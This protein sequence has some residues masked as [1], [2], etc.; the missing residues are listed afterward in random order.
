M[1]RE[2]RIGNFKGFAG[3]HSL[4][5]G[6]IN[7]F[8]GA[9]SAGK[10]ALLESLL[11]LRQSIRRSSIISD[12]GM[13]P[14]LFNG[15]LVD[16]GSFQATIN[17]HNIS[18][19]LL[20]GG[21]YEVTNHTP[22]DDKNPDVQHFDIEVAWDHETKSQVLESC[23]YRVD[24]A[25]ENTITFK[26][27][28][29]LSSDSAVRPV[30]VFG[31]ENVAI[32]VGEVTSR[33]L[34]AKDSIEI[35]ESKRIMLNAAYENWSFL[36][37]IAR[38][39]SK[40][41]I[42]KKEL[43]KEGSKTAIEKIEKLEEELEENIQ[44]VKQLTEEM[45]LISWRE[46]LQIRFQD[47]LNSI[48]GIRYLGPLRKSP[49][50]IERLVEKSK[51][52][53]GR[54]GEGVASILHRDLNAVSTVNRYLREL[55]IPYELHV[56]KLD[57]DGAGILGEIIAIQVVD[58]RSNVILSLEDVGFGISQVLPL[59]VQ[60]AISR[61]DLILIEQPELHLH[62]AIQAHFADL[63]IE[64]INA[65]NK[66][67][68]IIETHSEHLL[69]RLQRRIRQGTLSADDLKIYFVGS[70]TEIGSYFQLIELDD[71]GE[72]ITPWPSGFFP[73]RFDELLG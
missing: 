56:R 68:F 39:D 8:Y 51:V 67:Q 66:N 12:Q 3:S 1:F 72:F 11:L 13:D 26:R 37:G 25:P 35:A 27:N 6:K 34:P 14:L 22:S 38:I 16:L 17:G 23:T 18:K 30:E 63:L 69:L 55:A 50:R 71:Q 44:F 33:R 31:F 9:N 21:S 47:T 70:D 58:L 40:P 32:A 36:P 53:V 41:S 5:L 28:K 42:P 60:L 45:T 54:E 62:P 61:T 48:S 29:A 49:T 57:P 24:T 46:M 20:L 7:L 64:G 73:E 43:D 2:L 19:K 52:Y 10:S 59:I 4:E 65:D 15:S